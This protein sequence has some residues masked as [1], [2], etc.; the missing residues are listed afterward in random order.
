MLKQMLEN[1]LPLKIVSWDTED[2]YRSSLSLC[3]I[4]NYDSLVSY[5]DSLSDFKEDYKDFY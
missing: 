5:L 3:S 4:G 2:L 1:N